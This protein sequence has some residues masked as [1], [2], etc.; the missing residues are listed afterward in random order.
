MK[1]QIL[2]LGKALNKAEQKQVNG[3]TMLASCS[4]LY[5]GNILH[6]PECVIKVISRCR[7]LCE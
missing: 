1:K 4:D 5:R 6:D 2:N 3:G 7:Y